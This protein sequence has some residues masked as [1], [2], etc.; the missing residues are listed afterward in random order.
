MRYFYGDHPASQFE[1]GQSM[2]GNFPCTGCDAKA[3]MFRDITHRY[4]A[5]SVTYAERLEMVI[6]IT[7]F[8]V[9]RGNQL[10]TSMI[11]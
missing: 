10:L 11:V 9:N 5:K 4:R 7:F 2:G 8:L 6:A 3:T 1:A